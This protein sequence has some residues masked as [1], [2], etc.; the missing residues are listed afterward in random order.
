M[1][2]LVRIAPSV[3]APRH[4][5]TLWTVYHSYHAFYMVGE[6]NNTTMSL[7]VLTF[8]VCFGCMS[9][10]TD[11]ET[12]K[13]DRTALSLATCQD[14]RCIENVADSIDSG[15]PWDIVALQEAES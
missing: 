15:G 3:V 2:Q 5:V 9:A 4:G 8:N 13:W 10:K 1:L 12:A 14:E 7:K 11:W 6:Y